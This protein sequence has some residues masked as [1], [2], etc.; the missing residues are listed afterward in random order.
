MPESGANSELNIVRVRNES[1]QSVFWA[2]SAE[3]IMNS[4]LEKATMPV[5]MMKIISMKTKITP[6]DPTFMKMLKSFLLQM[7]A[8]ATNRTIAQ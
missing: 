4:V 1:L 2:Y 5:I 8:S 7:M 6:M 3:P